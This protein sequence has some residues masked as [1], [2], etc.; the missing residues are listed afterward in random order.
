MQSPCKVTWTNHVAIVLNYTSRPK[1][2]IKSIIELELL[3]DFNSTG[4]LCRVKFSTSVT[5]NNT[6]KL[7]KHMHSFNKQA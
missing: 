2:L 5:N 6:G 1:F 4:S 3:L 7:E